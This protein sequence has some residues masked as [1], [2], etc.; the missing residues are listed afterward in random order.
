MCLNSKLESGR[1][2]HRLILPPRDYKFIIV[3]LL[4]IVLSSFCQLDGIVTVFSTCLMWKVSMAKTNWTDMS[5][6]PVMFNKRLIH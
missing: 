3:R 5:L 2:G 6:I 1:S 4:N